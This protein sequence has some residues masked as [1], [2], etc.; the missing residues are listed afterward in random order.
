GLFPAEIVGREEIYNS[1][2]K[3]AD[4]FDETHFPIDKILP[5]EDPSMVAVRF[6]GSLKMK[7]GRGTY[8]NDY[9]AIF[10]FDEHGRILEW[11]EYYNPIIAAKAFGWIDKIK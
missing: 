2:R 6:T 3:A 11:I 9:F 10:S 7:N 4:G 8:D 5:F 1:L